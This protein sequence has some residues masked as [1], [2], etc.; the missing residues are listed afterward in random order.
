MRADLVE[1]VSE[2]LLEA[3]RARRPVDLPE[4]G[5]EPTLEDAHA[6]QD[7]VVAA[8]GGNGGW[9]VG[10]PS[11]TA[12]P[13]CSPLPGRRV[14]RGPARLPAAEYGRLGIEAEI[15]F[16][17]TSDL[18]PRDTPYTRSEVVAGVGAVCAAIEVV[19]RRWRAWPRIAPGWHAAD[20]SAN[21]ALIHGK[22]LSAWHEID[23]SIQPVRLEIEGQ[24]PAEAVGGNTAGDPV[25]LLVW[26]AN[27]AAQHGTGLQVGDVVTTGSCTGMS[28]AEPGNRVRATLQGIGEVEVRLES[29]RKSH[30]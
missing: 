3:R 15:A 25:R 2:L 23:L 27:H 10:A 11:R 22:G 12:E 8:L 17:I 19:D 28:F 24:P 4:N 1:R 13:S 18:P 9:K 29:D 6:I 26:L 21:G 20:L 14:F 5:P 16:R 30:V 7:R